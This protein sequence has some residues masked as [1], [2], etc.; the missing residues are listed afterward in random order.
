M[1]LNYY[2]CKCLLCDKEKE[3]LS[4]SIRCNKT[5]SCGCLLLSKKTPE[6]LQK[7][8]RRDWPGRKK[9]TRA[10]LEKFNFKCAKCNG[11]N[12]LEAHHILNFI[13]HLDQRNDIENGIC[14]CFCCHKKFHHIYGN[15]NNNLEQVKEFLECS[16]ENCNV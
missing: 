5:K 13:S 1:L 12:K 16:L 4:T 2:L 8:N 7:T 9:W 11:N 6:E 3:I 10:I 14:F 15:K